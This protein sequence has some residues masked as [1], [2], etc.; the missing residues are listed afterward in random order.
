MTTIKEFIRTHPFLN[1]EDL[2][3]AYGELVVDKCAEEA[4][5]TWESFL[6]MQE[7]SCVEVDKDSI[8]N[9]KKLLV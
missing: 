1:T 4:S 8:L 2:L 5:P 6:T 7:G 9:V 3:R